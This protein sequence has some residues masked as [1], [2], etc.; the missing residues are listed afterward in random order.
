METQLNQSQMKTQDLTRYRLKDTN[1]HWNLSPEELQRITVEKG[2]GKETNN[3]TLA[4]NTG[5]FTGRSP[6]DRFLVKDDYTKDR[7]WWGKTNKAISPENF[8]YL[9]SEIENYLS[10]KEIYVRDGYVCADPK[11]RMNVRTITQYPWSNMFIY[12][13]F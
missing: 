13:M 8:D 4:I 7:V 11:Y 6:Q 1:A 2:M 9:Q 12:N 5:K 3:G 10:G